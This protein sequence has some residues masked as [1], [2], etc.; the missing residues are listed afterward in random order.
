MRR[1]PFYYNSATGAAQ[2]TMPLDDSAAAAAAASP[3]LG[4]GGSGGCCSGRGLRRAGDFARGLF[5]QP[6]DDVAKYFGESIAFYFA[7]LQVRVARARVCV[8][9]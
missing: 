7:F 9:V 8:C 1:V 2:W 6:L 4:G 3:G 5:S